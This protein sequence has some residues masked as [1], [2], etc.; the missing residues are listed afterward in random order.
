MK[1]IA[2]TISIIALA[3]ICRGQNQSMTIA[4]T[5]LS[6][7]SVLTVNVGEEIDFFYGSGGSH[8]MTEGWNTGET[9]VVPFETQT[10]TS[11]I[12]SVTFSLE[13]PGTY[14]FHCGTNPM[15][16]GN[17]GSIIVVD[18]SI[19]VNDLSVGTE[20]FTVYPNPTNQIITIDG[21]YGTAEIFNIVGE[22]VM[23]VRNKVTSITRLPNGVYI[24]KM[25]NE[26][27]KFIKSVEN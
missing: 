4:H 26:Q 15:N 11:V 10:V 5:G 2:V 24:I 21:F 14:Y 23:D 3:I 16:Q 8:P 22:K 1:N 17:W 25:E 27:L 19:G 9:S 12:S 13:T 18:P 7:E 6:P 20:T